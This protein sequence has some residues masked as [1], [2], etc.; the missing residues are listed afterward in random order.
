M[1]KLVLIFL[2]NKIIFNNIDNNYIFKNELEIKMKYINKYNFT[3]VDLFDN[4]FYFKNNKFRKV[5]INVSNNELSSIWYPHYNY[6][7]PILSIKYNKSNFYYN[8]IKMQNTNYYENKY[9][10]PFDNTN[11]L[12]EFL[13]VYFSLFIIRPV[14]RY[15][16]EEKHREFEKQLAYER[17]KY[18]L[19]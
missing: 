17:Q 11:N 4:F 19:I 8:L 9:I 7:C 6:E 2:L 1:I 12:N 15:E 10:K 13:V 14:N 18:D 3:K 5:E 16:I